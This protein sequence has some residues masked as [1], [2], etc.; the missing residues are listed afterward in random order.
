MDGQM[1]EV[2]SEVIA[3]KEWDWNKDVGQW[4]RYRIE[5]Y[6]KWVKETYGLKAAKKL[7]AHAK[8]YRAIMDIKQSVK[9]ER[10]DSITDML[11]KSMQDTKDLMAANLLRKVWDTDDTTSKA[12]T[13]DD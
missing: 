1:Q 12:F 11:A 4:D 3:I 8:Q 13:K 9:E 2:Y 10:S 7:F 6:I 5:D